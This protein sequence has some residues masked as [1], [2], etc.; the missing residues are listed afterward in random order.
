MASKTTNLAISGL[1]TCHDG[2]Q[3]GL[4]A[5]YPELVVADFDLRDHRSQK[6]LPGL[7]IPSIKLF[8]HKLG[9]GCEAIWGDARTRI[10]LDHNP[11][12]ASAREI[13]LRLECVDPLFQLSI[14]VND[15][16]F[17]RAIEPVEL[18]VSGRELGR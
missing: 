17:D 7:G 8:S 1:A 6:G 16:I 18:F 15:A 9:E 4:V 11:I 14:K 10:G 3:R 12:K 13:A 5:D 2:C